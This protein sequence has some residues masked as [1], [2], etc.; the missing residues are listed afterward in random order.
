MLPRQP[1]H[2]RAASEDRLL[3]AL[4]PPVQSYARLDMHSRIL[5]IGAADMLGAVLLAGVVFLAYGAPLSYAANQLWAGIWCFVPAWLLVAKAQNLYDR[6]TLLAGRVNWARPVMAC[7]MTFG[8]VLFGS[9][10]IKA[11]GDL[12]RVWFLA[13]AAATLAWTIG[14]RLAMQYW[15]GRSLRRGASLERAMVLAGTSRA[16]HEVGRELEQQSA[17]RIRAAA[18][19]AIPGVAGG[20][21]PSWVEQPI[22][23]GLIDRVFVADFDECSAETN[24]LVA[25]LAQLAVDV[26]LV[27]DTQAVWAPVRRVG[28]VGLLP[29][30]DVAVRPLSPAQATIKRAEDIVVAAAAVLVVLPVLALIAILIRLDSPG[31]VLFRQERTGFH[32]QT[33][34][35]WKFRTM[36]HH[37]HDSTARVQTSRD[38][39]R[40]TRVGRWLRRTSLDELPQL[41]N[42]LRGEMSLVGPRPHALEMTAAGLPLSTVE[43]YA[44]RHRIRPGITG[45]AQVNGCR[46][47]VDSEAKLRERVRLDC[48][49][50]D[51]WSILLDAWIVLRTVGLMMFGRG[52]Y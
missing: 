11:S 28:A 27:L 42:V 1:S 19:A 18:V 47:E 52:A 8:L 21:P 3:S 41:F 26:T 31:P 32:D 39:P 38:D 51:N 24:A 48:Y 29:A 12:S 4:F 7:A 23:N 5:A 46:G 15:I 36:Y 33:F 14:V 6:S 25:R 9:F 34:R 35:V 2:Y 20:P 43:D 44:A 13:W 10:A 50:I 40:V 30:V 45:W 22:R 16:A 49:Y 17:G 37:L